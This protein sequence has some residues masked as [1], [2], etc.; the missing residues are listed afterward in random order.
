MADV[1]WAIGRGWHPLV[2]RLMADLLDLGWD[3]DITQI[4]EKMG[5]LRFYVGS[6]SN[7]MAD[8]ITAAE[9]KSYDICETCGAPGKLRDSNH[10]LATRCDA[11][12]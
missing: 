9:A 1:D 3:G 2:H 7:D 11:H 12:A 4:K 6:R 8:L 10:W 5:G